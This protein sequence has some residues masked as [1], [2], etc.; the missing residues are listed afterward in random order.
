MKKA[1]ELRRIS[2]QNEPAR[3]KRELEKAN[4]ELTRILEI[5]EEQAAKG[6]Y[7]YFYKGFLDTIV[8]NQLEQ[9]GYLVQSIN[10]GAKITW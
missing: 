9:L 7:G 5:C 3:Q 8:I 10:E 2:E 4:K 6:Y 1:H